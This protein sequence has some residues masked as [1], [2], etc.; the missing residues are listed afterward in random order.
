VVRLTANRRYRLIAAIGVAG[1][2][3]LVWA[4]LAVGIIG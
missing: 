2:F 4:Q 1:I 3:V